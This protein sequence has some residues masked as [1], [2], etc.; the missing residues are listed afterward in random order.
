MNDFNTIRLRVFNRPT[1]RRYEL[2]HRTYNTIAKNQFVVRLDRAD[3]IESS[4]AVATSS[5][6][7][8]EIKGYLEN[9]RRFQQE[10]V[11]LILL[12]HLQSPEKGSY[13]KRVDKV[14]RSKQADYILYEK[15]AMP[16]ELVR[17]RALYDD[18]LTSGLT[19]NLTTK[20]VYTSRN[21]IYFSGLST[22]RYDSE[23]HYDST[24]HVI[25]TAID[26]HTHRYHPSKGSAALTL[27]Q[28]PFRFCNKNRWARCKWLLCVLYFSSADDAQV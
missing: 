24:M 11:R 10:V 22:I 19:S 5:W 18:D 12:L 17:Q 21:T 4:L 2:I 20:R 3:F 26:S 14:V 13:G 8:E 1:T 7:G 28:E 15:G 6:Y 23:T 16:N 9:G 27:I 25:V